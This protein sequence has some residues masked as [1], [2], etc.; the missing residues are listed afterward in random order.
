MAE[1]LFELGMRLKG[2]EFVPELREAAEEK[3]EEKY[4]RISIEPAPKTERLSSLSA[5]TTS[6]STTA[7]TTSRAK[8]KL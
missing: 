6:P 4:E 7:K 8:S 1:L 5:D 3:V 2:S